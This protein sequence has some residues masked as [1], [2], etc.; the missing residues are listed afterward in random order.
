MNLTD[1]N[2]PGLE[3]GSTLC[4]YKIRKILEL[5]EIQSIYYELEHGRTHARHIH[6]SSGD[7]ENT[8]SVALKTVPRDST[9]VAHILEHTALCGSVNYPVRDPFFSMMKRSLS[10]FMNALTASDWT[11]YPFCTQNRKD[12]YN[13]MAV[14]LDSVFFPRLDR[15][16]F[17][18]EGHRLE[19]EPDPNDPGR[20]RLTFKGVVYNE[21]RGALSSPDQVMARSIL[22]ALYPDTT[23]GYNSGGNPLEIPDLTHEQL[24]AFHRRHYHPSN[25]YFYTYGNLPLEDHLRFIDETI[26]THFN[27]IDPETEVPSQPRWDAPRTAEYTYP[28]EPSEDDGRKCQICLAWLTADIRESFEILVLTILEQ[29]LL[30]NP[31]SPLRKALLDSG[32]GSTLSDGTGFDAENKDTMFACGLKDVA[33]DAGDALERLIFD[34]LREIADKG[35]EERL[36]ES[37]IHQIEFYRKEVTNTPFPYGLKLLLRFS[38]DW[39]HDGDPAIALQFD[40]LM[41]RL[42]EERKKP[43]F[44]EGRIRQYFL[45][46][47]HRVRLR[48]RPDPEQ[49]ER[50]NRILSE[51]LKAIEARLSPA[52]IEAIDNDT[53]QLIELQEAREDLSCLPTLEREDIPPSVESVLPAGDKQ[54]P[55]V[56]LYEQPTVGILY[57]TAVLGVS[58]L[59]EELLDLLPFFCYSLTRMG[60]PSHEPADISQLIDLYTGG[61][62]L[63]VNAGSRFAEDPESSCLPVVTFNSK[64]LSRNRENMFALAEELLVTVAFSDTALLKRLL[65][66][67]RAEMESSVVSSGHRYAISLAARNFTL[68]NALNEKWHGIHQL[69]TIKAITEDL[70][71]ANLS[72]IAGR[73]H[74]LRDRLF[75]GGEMK[76]ALIGEKPDLGP[77]MDQV[78]ELAR[79]MEMEKG[80]ADHFSAPSMLHLPDALPREGWSTSSAVSFVASVFKTVRMDHEDAPALAVISKALRSMFLHREIREK[81]GAYGGFA[82]YQ[83]ENGLF[84][85]GS[86]RDPH[87]INTLNVYE[88]ASTFIIAGDY[89]DENIKEAILQVCADIDR[90]DPPGPAAGKA[91]YR[92]LINLSD[93][94]RRQFKQK[95]VQLDRETVLR[96]AQR[97]F[98]P[99]KAPSAVAVIS[100]ETNLV[101]ANRQLSGNPLE[102]RHI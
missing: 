100:N 10:T 97:Y 83:P 37:A 31:G 99:G 54:S 75:R 88:A 78:A 64:C 86:Y 98:G 25:A 3:E 30:G 92:R 57:L 40:S 96:T 46:N 18:Q 6:I 1:A 87:I 73:L 62:S 35:I 67:Y 21:M 71:E 89:T 76:V 8:F 68:A 39:L 42:Q 85:F 93:E 16:S 95:L 70:S 52:D 34:T 5:P 74:Q 22:N 56:T 53:R 81:G 65:M 63:S 102:L 15:L 58:S 77:A 7:T 94:T 11:M 33:A 26:L 13:L 84:Y 44:L 23:Y 66:E 79:K 49:A 29:V 24:I 59:P 60:T 51:K 82:A 91:F 48:L 9:G 45:D 2:N 69:E 101:A 27:T 47:P 14:Y 36:V 80:S 61:M 28:L 55:P 4:G 20:S 41:E 12:F 43:G 50:E 32:I 72:E 38:G 19:F 17:K 90:P